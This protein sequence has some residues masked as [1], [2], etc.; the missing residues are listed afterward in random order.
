MFDF[1]GE[2]LREAVFIETVQSGVGHPSWKNCCIRQTRLPAH[3]LHVDLKGSIGLALGTGPWFHLLVLPLVERAQDKATAEAV[4]L[5][6]AQL[7]QNPSAARHNS[8]GSDQ[9]V[10]VQLP[11]W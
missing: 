11:E 1:Y 7:W 5:D 10:Q 6:H 9:L 2:C 4:V 8:A 3:L